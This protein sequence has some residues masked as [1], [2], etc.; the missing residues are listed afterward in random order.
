MKVCSV[1]APNCCLSRTT[2]PLVVPEQADYRRREAHARFDVSARFHGRDRPGR[3][4]SIRNDTCRKA[5]PQLSGVQNC[6]RQWEVTVHEP[7]LMNRSPCSNG[8]VGG[9]APKY[10]LQVHH[11]GKYCVS[12][13]SSFSP[14]DWEEM[15]AP[16]VKTYIV[17]SARYGT[18]ISFRRFYP[19]DQIIDD[20]GCSESMFLHCS[21][22]N[23]PRNNR[24]FDERRQ[25]RPCYLL[26]HHSIPKTA[27]QQQALQRTSLHI[28]RE[29]YR[30]RELRSTMTRDG[31]LSTYITYLFSGQQ[32]H[33]P[34][35]N[36][37]Q[38]STRAGFHDGRS[39]YRSYRSSSHIR[40]AIMR[41][42]IAFRRC[43]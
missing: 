7:R 16:W 2:H 42:P 35:R 8:P 17:E 15:G 22:A 29:A 4:V 5:E 27:I 31:R 1:H 11:K 33:D 14:P 10:L 30:D 43:F 18:N 21:G 32:R 6:D 36:R 40:L 20:H 13:K 34:Y 28:E 12:R 38:H 19:I 3:I 25:N 37:R 9:S 24:A 39:R 23:G 26:V 41:T